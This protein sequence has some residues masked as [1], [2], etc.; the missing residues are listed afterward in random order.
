ML[1][2]LPHHPTGLQGSGPLLV[3]ENI[4]KTFRAGIPGCWASATVLRGIDL[5]VS[6]GEVVGIV[7]RVGSGKT[8]LLLCAAGMLRP[9]RGVVTRCGDRP[10]GVP[11]VA[12]VAEQPHYHPFLTPRDVLAGCRGEG[13]VRRR[14]AARAEALLDVLSLRD[15]LAQHVGR[16]G[17]G[18]L[19][20]LALVHAVASAAPVLLLDGT[21]SALGDRAPE[22]LGGL[23]RAGSAVIVAARERAELSGVATREL[24]LLSDGFLRPV[25]RSSAG[26]LSRGARRAAA[27]VAE[28]EPLGAI[29]EP[30][31]PPSTSG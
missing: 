9:D 2:D 21:L 26:G 7:G 8:T 10:A 16:L 5:S 17:H 28:R 30:P 18:V 11:A 24:L 25:P 4:H 22:V 29:V 27:R 12:Y 19:Q 13:L 20:R 3:L 23:V 1:S 15:C 6:A 14:A 31:A